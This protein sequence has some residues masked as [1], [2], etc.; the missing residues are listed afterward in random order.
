MIHFYGNT[1]SIKSRKIKTKTIIQNIIKDHHRTLKALDY[2][3]VN[4]EELL[5]INIKML[6]HN[7]Y[8]DIIT[9][10]YTE[11]GGSIEGEIYISLDRVRE[12]ART[13]DQKFHVELLRVILHGILHI[14]GY[15]DKTK[16]QK[17]TMREKEDYY[18]QQYLTLFHVEQ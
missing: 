14:V 11:E 4:D 17:A 2:I 3:F 7:F 9:F 16:I 1:N 6:N 13:F 15:K 8:T 12:N 5:D 18:I 10:D